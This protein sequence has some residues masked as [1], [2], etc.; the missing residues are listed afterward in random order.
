MTM[1]ILVGLP[2]SGKSERLISRVNAVR[3]A[4]GAVVVSCCSDSVLLRARPNIVKRRRIA[5]RAGVKTDID[6]FESTGEA[7]KFLETIE[8]QCLLAYEEAQYFGT[9]IV[10]AW[11]SAS[12]RGVEI[13]IASPTDEQVQMLS[14]AGHKAT[15]LSFTCQECGVRDA[16][17]FFCHMDENRTVSV[18]KVCHDSLRQEVETQIVKQLRANAPHAGKEALYQ[19][20]ELPACSNWRVI[21]KD[22]EARFQLIRRA[23]EAVGLPSGDNSYLDIGCNTGFFCYQMSTIG[24][25]STGVDVMECDIKLAR[26][27]STYCRRDYA[28]YRVSD[29]YEYLKDS[30][31]VKFDVTSAL[32]VFQWVM[33]Q[34][35]AQHGLHCLNWLFQKSNSLCVLELGASKEDHYVNRTG[36]DYDSD[37]VRTYM[38]ASGEF[39]EVRVYEFAKHG[40]K[41]DLFIGVKPRKV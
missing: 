18:C 29:V 41:R 8:P 9:E 19:P 32:S 22:S 1:E 17:T 30:Q 11:L 26:L 21:R 25:R 3:E 12:R 23:C 16:E 13:I 38:E 5:S 35:S 27:L 7:I 14:E 15:V 39:V 31:D 34:K 4:G 10:D 2:G 24:F 37:W 36:M 6:R 40:L 20:V 28:T 33:I